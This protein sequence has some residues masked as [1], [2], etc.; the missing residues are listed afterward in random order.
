MHGLTSQYHLHKVKLVYKNLDQSRDHS[1]LN[2]GSKLA[3]QQYQKMTSNIQLTKLELTALLESNPKQPTCK[4]SV[5][6]PRKLLWKKMWNT[7][8][9]PRNGCDGRLKAKI[10]NN[11][12]S[13][14][15]VYDLAPNL[16][17]LSMSNFLPLAHHHSH[18]LAT[19][20]D[21][22]SFLQQHCWGMHTSF[23][24]GLCYELDFT[25]FCNCIL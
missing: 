15:F 13:S 21:F 1:A 3:L 14:E 16:P 17:K 2:N 12:N 19:T 4:K 20:L 8:W 10:F 22:T 25:S 7:K 5:Q 11:N 6:P 18:F 24:T 23:T 9:Q